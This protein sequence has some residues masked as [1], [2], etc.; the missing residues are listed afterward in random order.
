[1]INANLAKG[2]NVFHLV[3]KKDGNDDKQNLVQFTIVDTYTF[4]DGRKAND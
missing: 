2:F 1:V 3:R 4:V